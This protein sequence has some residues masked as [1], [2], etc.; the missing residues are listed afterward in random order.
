MANSKSFLWKAFI[1]TKRSFSLNNLWHALYPLLFIPPA[2]AFAGNS[3]PTTWLGIASWVWILSQNS[4]SLFQ[5]DLEQWQLTRQ[6]PCSIQNWGGLIELS[7]PSYPHFS[8]FARHTH[9]SVILKNKCLAVLAPFPDRAHSRPAAVRTR[10]SQQNQAEN[11]ISGSLRPIGLRGIALAII[12]MLLPF[13]IQLFP[14]IQ[15]INL[16]LAILTALGLVCLGIAGF[17]KQIKSF[18]SGQKKLFILLL[19]FSFRACWRVF[20]S[21]SP[22]Q[23]LLQL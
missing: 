23:S 18:S 12:C 16:I 4:L 10:P 7:C 2:F 3:P 11:L 13:L 6:L 14:P 22:L 20:E 19:I 1:I 15:P 8:Q 21:R 17:F 5:R 9:R